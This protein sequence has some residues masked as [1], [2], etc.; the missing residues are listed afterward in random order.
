MLP[1]HTCNKQTTNLY[2]SLPPTSN[3]LVIKDKWEY[4]PWSNIA[5]RKLEVAMARLRLGHCCLNFH[6]HRIGVSDTPNCLYCGVEETIEHFLMSC[7]R[8]YSNRIILHSYLNS[9]G[10]RNITKEILLG[11]GNFDKDIK[12][13]VNRGVIKFLR[14][15][16]KNL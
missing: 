16:N 1:S 8:Y 14:T 7:H 10:I 11:G 5:N 2:P 9:L 6:L 13:K 3:Q 12:T 15:C 4:W